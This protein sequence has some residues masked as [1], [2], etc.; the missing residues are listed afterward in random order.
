[1]SPLRQVGR[2]PVLCS[3]CSGNTQ[4]NTL[5]STFQGI[6]RET[7]EITEDQMLVNCESDWV[8]V[9]AADTLRKGSWVSSLHSLIIFT[10]APWLTS[11]PPHASDYWNPPR[12]SRSRS[13]STLSRNPGQRIPCSLLR[14][15][16]GLV[17][18][19]SI[20]KRH[21]GLF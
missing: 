1:M 7:A 4:V 10:V 5:P 13:R 3:K 17:G 2:H 8:A 16:H 6:G 9:V 18:Y 19:L 20:S 15:I 12:P 14:H 11:H 21:L